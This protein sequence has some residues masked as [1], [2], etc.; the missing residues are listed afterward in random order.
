MFISRDPIGLLGGNN[1]FQYAPNP[2]GWVDPFGLACK[3]PNGYKTN[4]VDRHGNLSPQNNR[5]K[6]H[7]NHKD[8]NQIQ[9][10][11]PIQNAWAKKK[12]NDYNEN[13]AYGVLLPSSSGMSHARISTSQRMRRKAQGGWDTTLKD[14]FNIGYREMI[15]A[16]VHPKVAKK[17]YKKAYK[18]FDGLRSSNKENP[19]FDI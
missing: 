8:D 15:D 13:D 9:S 11:H 14:E 3:A 1:V 16:G 12:I 10:H 17:A 19:H 5:A 6:G 18:Y 7:T 2:I 4:D